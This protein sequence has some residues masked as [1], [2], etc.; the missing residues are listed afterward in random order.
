M[1]ASPESMTPYAW[2]E[3]QS[4]KTFALIGLIFFAIMAGVWSWAIVSD[5]IF[6][7]GPMFDGGQTFGWLFP[8]VFPNLLFLALSVGFAVWAWL[9]L[10]NIEVGR[11][12]EAQTSALVLG[13]F[14]LFPPIG[15]LIGGIFFLL[16]YSKLGSAIT[17]AQAPPPSVPATPVPAR[18]RICTA[19]G[20]PISMDAKF[21]QY[22]GKE[23]A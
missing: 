7:G 20:R 9:T 6:P 3:A 10:R 2:R 21:C 23:L 13:I 22:C 4:S 12:S 16:A 18:S 11:Y 15:A 17:Y 5:L 8:F 14:G 1:A 19:C